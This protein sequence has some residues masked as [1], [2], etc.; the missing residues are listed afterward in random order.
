MAIPS[1]LCY[2]Y[3][4]LSVINS[5]SYLDIDM[6]SQ[7]LLTS[8]SCSKVFICQVAQILAINIFQDCFQLSCFGQRQYGG[9]C[10][11]SVFI[12][13]MMKIYLRTLHLLFSKIRRTFSFHFITSCIPFLDIRLTPATRYIAAILPDSFM[14]LMLTSKGMLRR[15]R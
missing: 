14:L 9:G 3:T 10:S 8:L 15:Q 4:L 13:G 5:K 2:C 6:R 12:L 1:C 11:F 7:S